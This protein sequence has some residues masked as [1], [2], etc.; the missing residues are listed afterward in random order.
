MTPEKV[1][2]GDVILPRTKETETAEIIDRNNSQLV[3]RNQLN[4]LRS[5][6]IC[7]EMNWFTI[8]V[9]MKWN[10]IYFENSIT[11]IFV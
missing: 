9:R 7:L 5:L 1:I 8:L 2:L 11:N 4:T 6:A 3:L 10:I